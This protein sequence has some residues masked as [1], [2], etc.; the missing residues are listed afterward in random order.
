MI[1]PTIT[2][3]LG[4]K[5][6]SLIFHNLKQARKNDNLISNFTQFGYKFFQHIEFF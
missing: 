1:I 5:I 6:S 4:S 3:P 2:Q